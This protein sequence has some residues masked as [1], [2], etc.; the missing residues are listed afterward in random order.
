MKP[1]S[2]DPIEAVDYE[3]ECSTA[4][5][6]SHTL[7]EGGPTWHLRLERVDL[8]LDMCRLRSGDTAVS[9]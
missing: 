2:L 8:T 4:Q 3:S 1:N 9:L 5:W 7:A 6:N